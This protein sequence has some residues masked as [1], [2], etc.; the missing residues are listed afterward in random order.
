[1]ELLL[2]LDERRKRVGIEVES[3]DNRG[4]DVRSLRG[5]VPHLDCPLGVVRVGHVDTASLA[6][7]VPERAGQ[8]LDREPVQPVGLE[9]QSELTL[10]GFALALD[11]ETEQIRKQ[12]LVVDAQTGQFPQFTGIDLDNRHQ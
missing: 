5:C 6:V 8:P 10:V 2:Q 9:L 1:M 3:P 12:C 4:C 11:T 7:V